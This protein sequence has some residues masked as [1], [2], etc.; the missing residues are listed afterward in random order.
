MHLRNAY[1]TVIDWRPW[2]KV[3]VLSDVAQNL[4]QNGWTVS[5]N[6]VEYG[7][8]GVGC[9]SV[10]SVNRLGDSSVNNVF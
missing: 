4:A 7:D 8:I 9:Q 3:M 6:I 2:S 1:G 10:L 5:E